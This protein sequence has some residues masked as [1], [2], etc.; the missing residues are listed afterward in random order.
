[1]LFTCGY[2]FGK[3]M[4]IP[5]G[6]LISS[7]LRRKICYVL[8]EGGWSLLKENLQMNKFMVSDETVIDSGFVI[9]IALRN[10]VFGDI[11]NTVI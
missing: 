8:G 2:F 11:Y 9:T 10:S 6:S 1:M 3:G 5:C 4:K 7:I